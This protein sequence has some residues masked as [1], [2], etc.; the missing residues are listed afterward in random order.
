MTTLVEILKARGIRDERLL[1]AFRRVDRAGFVPPEERD[2]AYLDRPVRIPE[3]QVTTQPSLIA[4]MVEA[5]ELEGSEIVLEIGTGY[6]FQTAI[7]ACLCA[8]VYSIE[9][10]PALSERAQRNLSGRGIRNAA[11][12]VGDGTLGLPDFAPYDAIVCSAAARRVPLA[13]IDQLK[14]GGRL[15]IPLGPGG[16]ERVRLF[17]KHLGG[18]HKVRDLTGAC[19]V[20]LIGG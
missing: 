12:V 14:E 5:L 2:Q 16:D 17:R 1:E 19:F 20:P 18:L 4:Q 6:G 10:L 15:V 8:H 11:L 9:R 3:G 7:L 13:L